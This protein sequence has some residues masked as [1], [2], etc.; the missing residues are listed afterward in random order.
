MSV[1]VSESVRQELT[2]PLYDSAQIPAAGAL[3]LTFFQQPFGAGATIFGAGAKN[4]CDTNMT[5]AG[6]IP[7]GWMFTVHAIA[8]ALWSTAV[9]MAADLAIALNASWFELFLGS[10]T[11]SVFQIPAKR[12]T[13]GCGVDGYAATT[14]AA[15]SQQAAHNG[16]AD[17]RAIYGLKSP[18]KIFGG[19][20]FSAT[21]N[22]SAL[23]PTTAAINATVFLEG[24]LVREI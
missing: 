17:P 20:G 15:T 21:L 24:Q 7:A 5:L 1:M 4:L 2:Q 14:V 12:L 13:G 23:A 3:K 22:W 6:Q 8:L 9:T 10:G 19:K 18:L 16:A 11:Q